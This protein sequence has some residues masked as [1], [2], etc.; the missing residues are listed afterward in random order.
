MIK[1]IEKYRT[2]FEKRISKEN[3]RSHKDE[4]MRE[5]LKKK[6]QNYTKK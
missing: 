6:K 2:R 5:D 1:K 3:I 4:T